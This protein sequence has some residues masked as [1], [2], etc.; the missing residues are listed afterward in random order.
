MWSQQNNWIQQI[1]KHNLCL[2]L[3]HT[4]NQIQNPNRNVLFT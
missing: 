4:E 1:K 2:T 3:A